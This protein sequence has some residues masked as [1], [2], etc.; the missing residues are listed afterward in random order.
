MTNPVIPEAAVEAVTKVLVA[1]QRR[2]NR[3]CLCGWA[4]L[5]FSHPTHQAALVLEAAAPHML[6]EA[7]D[8]AIQSADDEGCLLYHQAKGLKAANPYRGEA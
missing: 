8:E 3:S 6:A 2:D 4:R 5:G 1:H 7:W